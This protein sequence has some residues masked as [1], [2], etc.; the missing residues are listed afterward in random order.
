MNKMNLPGFTA[1]ASLFQASEVYQTV[2]SFCQNVRSSIHPAQLGV[3]IKP[4]DPSLITSPSCV[5]V[6]F[7]KICYELK[8][9]W[10]GD[11][12]IPY[13]VPYVCGH[14]FCNVC[15]DGTVSCR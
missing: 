6:L 2:G 10:V 4:L 7:P 12:Q 1:G 14:E 5:E 11:M 13:V 9:K 8:K 15:S 3:I